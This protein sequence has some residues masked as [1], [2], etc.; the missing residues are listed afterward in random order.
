M[1][2]AATA[3]MRCVG[4]EKWELGIALEKRRTYRGRLVFGGRADVGKG[5]KRWTQ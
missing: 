3:A 1:E 5:R 4:R 2:E